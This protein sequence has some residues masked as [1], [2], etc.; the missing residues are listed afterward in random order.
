MNKLKV[1]HLNVRSLLPHMSELRKVILEHDFHVLCV[2]ETW[3]CNNNSDSSVALDGY[4]FFRQDRLTRGGGVGVY[5]KSSLKCTLLHSSNNIEQLWLKV[6]IGKIS[7]AVC[8]F[9]RPP[10]CNHKNFLAEF[11]AS[12]ALILPTV[13]YVMCLGDFNVDFLDIG[14]STLQEVTDFFDGLGLTQIVK[15]PTRITASTAK[16]LDYVL[17]TNDMIVEDVLTTH[18]PEIS[19]H[20]LVHCITNISAGSAGS[21]LVYKKV[22]NFR[23]LNYNQFQSDLM[24]LPWGIIYDLPDIDSKVNLLNSNILTLL[25][26][27]APLINIRITKPYAPWLTDSIR[28]MMSDRDLALRRFRCG[29]DKVH[30]A[31]YKL[32][33]NMITAAIRREK[34]AYF[35][36]RI[37]GEGSKK[38]W[39]TLKSLNILTNKNKELPNNMQDPDRIND[40]FISAAPDLEPD[41]D[42]LHYYLNNIK[43]NTQFRLKFDCVSEIEVLNIISC[44][45]SRATGLDGINIHTINLCMPFL[46][47]YLTHIINFCL[48]NSV[49]P[50]C[51]GKAKVIPLPKKANPASIEDLR[52][53]SVLPAFS[54]VLEKVIERQT[55]NYLN[56][57]KII[58]VN[59]SG[60][61][62]GYSCGTALLKIT[63]DIIK[64]IDK[65][66][67]TILVLLDFSKAFDTI[68]HALLL[69]IFRFLGFSEG[70]QAFFRNYLDN[71]Y[72]T[73]TCG[74]KISRALKIRKG[75]AQGSILGP[76]MFQ[77]Y[78]SCFPAACLSCLQHYYADDTQLY[79]SFSEEESKQAVAAVNFDLGGIAQVA[80]GHCLM[81]NNKKSSAIIFGKN[82]D[83][84]RFLSKFSDSVLIEGEKILFQRQVKN[85]GLC[86]DEN[87][88]FT[89]HVTEKLKTSYMNLRTLYVNRH[90]L[91]TKS[92]RILCESLVLSQFSHCDAVYG[93]CLTVYDAGR[94][95]GVQNSCLRLIY[96]IRKFQ[97]IS[98]TFKRSG[99]LSMSN[100]RFIHSA[101]LYHNVLL[102][103]TP[104]YL[105]NKISFRTDIHN[106]NI[107]FK[108]TLTIP[109]H[110]SQFFKR[111]FSYNVAKVINN[112]SSEIKNPLCISKA[113]FKKSVIKLVS[114]A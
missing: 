97:H 99:W 4:Q 92:K 64:A 11:E 55:A 18:V 105:Y 13:R 50:K 24:S 21:N 1:A 69:S 52:P 113:A 45:K 42:L 17:V 66:K 60:F 63:D 41:K 102:T 85:L 77:I 31:E 10:D 53:I 62:K 49:F 75:V 68:N 34:K 109:A 72:Q 43:T 107:R 73:V 91:T 44:I 103:K 76:M 48:K 87:L 84:E 112:I 79:L 37:R 38:M 27:H 93:P 20:E 111:C 78:T 65:N 14:S 3:L 32:L 5:I 29:G 74:N 25:D 7:L 80:R 33:R 56:K 108:N 59:Q 47:P 51:W 114:S 16:L 28:A 23:N 88:R 95:Q 81:L 98:S 83:R 19:D 106:I 54:K 40:L 57:Y 26:L 6:T 70:T 58:P 71:R 104:P 86:M 96:G 67:L 35:S 15:N 2:G 89:Q 46:L 36:N 100:R 12:Y 94:I 61:R 90:F 8:V 22:R 30:W 39:S 110:S 9:Y 82:I 101:C